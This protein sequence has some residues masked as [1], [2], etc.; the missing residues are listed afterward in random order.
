[1]V[2]IN[3]K[4]VKQL[5]KYNKKDFNKIIFFIYIYLYYFSPLSI[6]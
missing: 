3:V 5:S 1:M 4:K 6:G 2:V